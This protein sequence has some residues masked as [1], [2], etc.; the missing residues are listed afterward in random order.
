MDKV[1]ALA[2]ELG[3]VETF[4]VDRTIL[5]KPVFEGTSLSFDYVIVIDFESTCWDSKDQ[6]SKW[7][8]LAE[9]IEFPAV[10]LN[11][12]TGVI[13]DQFHQ[14]VMPVENPILSEFCTKLTGITQ[15][16]VNCGIPLGTC[17]MLFSQW[18][19]R[20]SSDKKITFHKPSAE[21]KTC[22]FV[23]WSDWD[24]SMCLQNETKR[25]QI[26]KPE[27]LSQWIDLRLCYRKFYKRKPQGLKG[28]LAELGLPFAGRE[29]SG[30]VDAKNTANLVCR[31][32]RDG[33]QL[34]I[35]SSCDLPSPP[36][37]GK[38]CPLGTL[39]N[40]S[41]P[42]SR[43]PQ[44]LKIRAIRG[45]LNS[46]RLLKNDCF[47]SM[48][49]IEGIYHDDENDVSTKNQSKI[50]SPT[51]LKRD[52]PLVTPNGTSTPKRQNVNLSSCKRTPPLCRCGRRAICKVAN[53]PGPNQGRSFF[54]CP[55]QRRSLGMVSKGCNFFMWC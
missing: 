14:Y 39:K 3:F 4:F 45:A 27:I 46:N 24:L 51:T 41:T 40:S 15:E 10:L 1:K 23:T 2:Q 22:T 31:M 9:I 16:V 33:C 34:E 48:K 25:K 7:Q 55:N 54:S 6:Q 28:A 11:L 18:I 8:N 42:L 13:E 47:R 20:L 29:H 44:S 49:P 43:A 52:L 35:T 32:L 26:R 50:I 37:N 5:S 12:K 30:I 36:I 17:M 21:C 53:S 19:N 38:R